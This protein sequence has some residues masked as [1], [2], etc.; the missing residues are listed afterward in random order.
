ME[1]PGPTAEDHGLGKLS[2]LTG[3]EVACTLGNTEADYTRYLLCRSTN[4]SRLPLRAVPDT[5][6]LHAKHVCDIG[7]WRGRL[8]RKPNR[9]L[10]AARY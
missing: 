3:H 8:V 7:D 6:R 5:K 10:C 4:I 9:L 2:T 1:K